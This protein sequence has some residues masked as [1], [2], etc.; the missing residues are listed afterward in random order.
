MPLPA[1]APRVRRCAAA[2]LLG[3][4]ALAGCTPGVPV[5]VASHAADPTCADVVLALPEDLAGMP[6]LRTAAQATAAWGTSADPV[7]LR[8]GVEPPGPTTQHCVTVQTPDGPSVDWLVRAEQPG[9]GTALPAGA[10]SQDADWTFTT[11]GRDPAIEVHVPA[12]VAAQRSTA[13]LD[14]VGPAVARS[15]QTRTCL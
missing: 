1:V 3:P 8:C 13:F 5:A 9:T 12:A 10:T 11:Y 15:P 6:R 7:V 14:E 2:L 4:A